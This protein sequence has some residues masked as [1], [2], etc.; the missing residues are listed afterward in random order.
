MEELVSYQNYEQY[1][2]AVDTVLN[3]TVEDFVITGY[4]LKKGRDTD[5]LKDSGYANVN[6]FAAAEYHLDATQVSRYIRINDKFS[7]GGYSDKLVEQYKGFG[8]TK[9]ALM[10]TLPDSIIEELSPTYSKSEIQAVKEE[11]EKEQEVTDI[12]VILEGE[13]EEQKEL[14]NLQKALNQLLE[15]EPDLF[16]KLYEAVKQ[17][18]S[19]MQLVKEILAPDREKLYSVRI[20]GCGRIMLFLNDNE[21][22]TVHKVRENEKEH[23]DWEEIVKY[24]LRIVT[25]QDGKERWEELYKKSFPEEKRE[26]APVQLKQEEKKP[27]PRKESKVNKAKIPKKE[28]QKKETSEENQEIPGQMEIVRDMPEYCP[29]DMN[30][31]ETA[32]EPEAGQQDTEKEGGETEAGEQQEAE[33]ADQEETI[34]CHYG[35]RKQYLDHLTEYGAALYMAASM[36]GMK[37]MMLSDPKYWESW[38]SEEVDD[39]GEAIEIVE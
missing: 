21:K 37:H 19:R 39:K 5:I 13:K 16:V 1:K 38:L 30:P 35:N 10:L 17:P 7:E 20:Q 24:L 12:E 33:K 31:P 4:L 8:Y 36:Q 9:L 6:D 29:P 14:N 32:S 25:D 27:K 11:I 15:D 2:T 23:Y 26:I 3:R 28:V 22:I 34:K 18:D